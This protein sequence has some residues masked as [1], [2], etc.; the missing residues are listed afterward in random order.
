MFQKVFSRFDRLVRKSVE[1]GNSF[2]IM[3]IE[4]ALLSAKFAELPD[5]P[6]VVD[7]LIRELFDHENMHVR[8]IAIGAC[9]RSQYFE[10]PGLRDALLRRLSDEEAWVRYDAAWAIGD[11]GYDDDE[12]RS[13]LKAAAGDA[14]LP[15]D[16]A[17]LAENPSDADRSAKVRALK[18]LNKIGG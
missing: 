18:S 5:Q 2:P 13:A 14:K 17:R 9:H 3:P 11:A 10:A 8:R 15:E 4:E 1:M 16:E 7:R 12:T 6:K